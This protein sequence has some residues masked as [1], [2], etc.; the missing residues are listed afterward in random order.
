[1]DPIV[2]KTFDEMLKLMED[3]DKRS[4]EHWERSE[5]R[6]EDATTTLH[7]REEA[8]DA[9][10]ASL[11]NF[12]STQYSAAI[13]ADNWGAHFDSRV[14]DLE[15]RMA[16]LELILLAEIHDEWDDR[17]EELEGAVRDLQSWRQ[18]VDGNL[19]NLH[20]EIRCFSKVPVVQ[21]HQH[22]LPARRELAA[23]AYSGGITVDW[24]NGHHIESTTQ[25]GAM[26]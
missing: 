11:E 20:Y 23:A 12:A 26:V 17:V 21:Q 2:A 24:P 13:I 19:D 7:E 6:F 8:V 1:M 18:E 15:Q 16:N 10:I 14:T 5:K 3:F 22:P 9:R 4:F 25:S